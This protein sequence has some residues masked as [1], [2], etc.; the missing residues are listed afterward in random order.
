LRVAY[1]HLSDV[2]DANP[3][4]R[5][6]VF[7]VTDGAPGC[8]ADQVEALEQCGGGFACV[9]IRDFDPF[10]GAT[11]TSDADCPPG[12]ECCDPALG[13]ANCPVDG[14]CALPAN[15]IK[16]V[17]PR[18]ALATMGQAGAHPNPPAGDFYAVDD[19][20]ALEAALRDI[21]ASLPTCT[22]GIP[23]PP[24]PE[25]ESMQLGYLTL[26]VGDKAYGHCFDWG[27]GSPVDNCTGPLSSDLA[28]CMSTGVP[29]LDPDTM[30]LTLCGTS[31]EDYKQAGALDGSYGCWEMGDEQA[32]TLW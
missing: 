18:E 7:Y 20:P 21:E 8:H 30:S 6:H 12:T 5:G 16:D 23:A 25:H 24:T 17:N 26:Y 31:C 13:S 3:G 32:P 28:A 10:A 4:S 2:R 14:T 11:C 1:G 27:D 22:V 9:Q 15:G 29:Y 19:A